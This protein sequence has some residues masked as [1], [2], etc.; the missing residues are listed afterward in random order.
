ML[1]FNDLLEE[2]KHE[3]EVTL[4]ELL[5][6]DSSDLVDIL[7]SYIFD[8]QDRLRAYYGESSEELGEQE[9]AN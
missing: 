4:L 9:I 3:D 8:R 6:L 1:T 2:L 5:N 7:E